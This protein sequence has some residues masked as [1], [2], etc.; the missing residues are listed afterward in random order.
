MRK[1]LVLAMAI[2]FVTGLASFSYGAGTADEA[3]AMVDKAIAFM[4]ANGKDKTLKEVSTKKGQFTKDDLYVFILDM[5]GI[6]IAHG[7]NEKLIGGD[8]TRLKDYDGRFFI[9]EIVEGAKTKGTGWVDY[10]WE[11]PSTKSVDN[12]S[13]Y[14]KKD[15]DLI[16]SCGIY[17][18]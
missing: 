18:K 17:K 9:K 8:L 2:I 14:F 4:K 10:H 16:F 12:K 7:A 13:T 11:N 5:S 15:G 6:C 3:K 1:L